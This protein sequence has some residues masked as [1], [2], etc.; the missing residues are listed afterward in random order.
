MI[1]DQVLES[2]NFNTAECIIKPFGNGLINH[3]WKISSDHSD[4]VYILQRINTNVF[5]QP[6]NIAANIDNI[7]NYLDKNNPDY[8]FIAPIKTTANAEMY[9]N[10]EGDFRVF[11]FLKNSCSIDV[12]NKPV[13]AFEFPENNNTGFS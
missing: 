3:T 8:L 6:E 4:D 12:V 11:P 2:Y 7:A 5:K 1:L 9:I 13:Q 10:E